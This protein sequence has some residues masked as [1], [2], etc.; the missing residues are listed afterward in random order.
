MDAIHLNVRLLALC[1]DGNFLR[2]HNLLW[3]VNSALR[4]KNNLCSMFVSMICINKTAHG[5]SGLPVNG[6]HGYY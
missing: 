1:S 6:I 3:K 2:D 4:G 5:L